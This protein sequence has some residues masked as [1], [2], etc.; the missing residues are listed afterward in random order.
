MPP[1]S[2]KDPNKPRGRKSAYAFYL[3]ERRKEKKGG[4]ENFTDFS[5]NSASAW[6]G[7][8]DSDKEKYYKMQAED[9]KRYDKEMESYEP[10][11]EEKGRRRKRKQK[12]DKNAP[13]RAM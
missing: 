2:R 12:K 6:H 13:K 9:K 4:A 11:K 7:L 10:P 5:K 1:K 3:Q 8:T